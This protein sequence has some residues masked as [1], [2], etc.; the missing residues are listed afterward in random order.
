MRVGPG[1]LTSRNEFEFVTKFVFNYNVNMSA[2]VG[3]LKGTIKIEKP[4]Y[5]VVYDDEPFSWSKIHGNSSLSCDWAITEK[6][7]G[8]PAKMKWKLL[9]GFTANSIYLLIHEHLRPRTWYFALI[10]QDC[11]GN[12]N[13]LNTKLHYDRRLAQPSLHVNT[14][15]ISYN[16]TK[17]SRAVAIPH[18]RTGKNIVDLSSLHFVAGME[19]FENQQS[20]KDH[21]MVNALD[22]GLGLIHLDLTFLNL[23]QGWQQHFGFD[24]YGI[25]PC[26]IFLLSVY[27][28]LFVY[29]MYTNEKRSKDIIEA[30][31]ASNLRR[32]HSA[33]HYGES[34]QRSRGNSSSSSSSSNA[35]PLVRMWPILVLLQMGSLLLRTFDAIGYAYNGATSTRWRWGKTLTVEIFSQSL[36]LICRLGLTMAV[37]LVA[38]GWTIT[39]GPGEV[40]GKSSI[41]T[42]FCITCFIEIGGRIFISLT[43]DPQDTTNGFSSYS[44]TIVIIWRMVQLIWFVTNIS[45]TYYSERGVKRRRLYILFG[46]IFSLWFASLP[47]VVLPVSRFVAPHWRY[48]IV[49]GTIDLIHLIALTSYGLLFWPTWSSQ[50]F[51]IRSSPGAI[52]EQN[53][54]LGI[55]ETNHR[56][57]PRWSFDE[58]SPFYQKNRQNSRGSRLKYDDGL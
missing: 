2:N 57:S 14:H 58:Y 24:E 51:E 36:D 41:L 8:G 18:A 49:Q 32:H 42:L 48:K 46:G 23:E 26:T 50:L 15:P 29:Q 10:A 54:L 6:E 19:K 55:I 27:I 39:S 3:Q 40:R 20:S 31:L 1:Q 4:A 35:P 5:F 37:F 9:P 25:L 7:R 45:F 11:T 43:Y 47:A 30:N 17:R 38:R 22:A 34:N 53:S 33:V 28:V 16:A 44:G 52:E 12:R 13:S 21:K 56:G